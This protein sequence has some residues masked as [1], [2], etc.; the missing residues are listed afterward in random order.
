[1]SQCGPVACALQR[2]ND[3][4]AAN[5]LASLLNAPGVY[6]PAFAIRGLAVLKDQRVIKPALAIATRAEAD[7]R[8]RAVAV[9]A[10][11][12]L[13]ESTAVHSLEAIVHNRAT[14]RSLQLEA[15]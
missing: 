9:R 10:L 13:G 7:A 3:A 6:T 8:L 15:I 12:Q 4:R 5:A 11:G 1:V 14:P 2:S